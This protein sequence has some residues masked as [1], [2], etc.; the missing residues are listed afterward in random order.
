MGAVVDDRAVHACGGRGGADRGGQQL[1]ARPG[2]RWGVAPVGAVDADD[3]VEVD[4][5]AFLVLGEGDAGVLAE[6]A[7][8]ETGALGDL[9]AEV[10]REAPPEQARWPETRAR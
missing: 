10:D 5:A 1:G 8:G 3:G 4:G 7:L 9:P 6:G 2:G